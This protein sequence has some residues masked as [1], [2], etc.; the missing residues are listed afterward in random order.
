MSDLSFINRFIIKPGASDIPN[1]IKRLK[2]SPEAFRWLLTYFDASPSFISSL[3]SEHVPLGFCSRSF[4]DERSATVYTL[5]YALPIRAAAECLDKDGN[6]ALSTAGGYHMDSTG[7]LHLNNGPQ[8]IRPSKIGIYARYDRKSSQMLCVD[9]QDGRLHEL[10]DVPYS[11]LMELINHERKFQGRIEPASIH[12]IF[13]SVSARWWTRV[14][15][16]LKIQLIHYVSL[17]SLS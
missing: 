13:L 9:F 1:D 15:S 8:D 12:A 5:W 4:Q 16:K 7:Y 6:H 2:V 3:L 17:Y 11:R 10:A 14:L